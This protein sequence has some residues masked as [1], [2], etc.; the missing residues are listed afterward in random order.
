MSPDPELERLLRRGR[1][2]LPEPDGAATLAARSRALRAAGGPNRR[3]ARR[4]ALLVTALVVAVAVGVGLGALIAPSGTAA[5]RATAVGFVPEP[6]WFAL[7]AASPS[8]GSRN[9]VAMAANV[10]FAAEDV[11]DGL[12]EQSALPYATL[13]ALPPHGAVIVASFVPATRRA[14]ISAR[15]QPRRLPLRFADAA[16]FIAWGTQVRPGQPLGQ[17]QLSALVSGQQ[18][19]LHVY[20]GTPDPSRALRDA[21]QRQLDRLVVRSPSPA[22]DTT[23]AEQQVRAPA[24]AGASADVTIFARPT[25]LG[26][27]QT[28]TLYGSVDG[29]GSQDVVSIQSRVCGF[30]FFKPHSEVHLNAGGG[31]STPVGGGITTTYR[32]VWKGRRSANVTIWSGA[33][34]YLEPTRSRNR[35][36]VTVVSRRSL[37]RRQV[38]I[39]R[40]EAS[41]WR[42]LRTVVLSDSLPGAGVTSASA[43]TFRL[44]VP[45]GTAIRA[46]LP[47]SEA[48]P[49]YVASASKAVRT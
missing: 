9:A 12:A 11:V 27:T 20:F 34:V 13:R 22:R 32:A 41:G 44:S 38:A 45:R 7:H 1:E 43:A 4:A 3:R 42:T 14:W 31:W 10:P 29:A 33:G 37:W 17:F 35:F 24:R 5:E 30:S 15:Y 49:C 26:W 18:V 21:V 39:Q 28:A 36:I 46:F 47:T 25:V 48:K 16:P 23:V 6:G 2:A 19:D 8:A 40:R